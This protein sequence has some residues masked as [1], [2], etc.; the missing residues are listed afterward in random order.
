[1]GDCLSSSGAGSGVGEIE[2]INTRNLMIMSSWARH[3]YIMLA[4]NYRGGPRS[5][6]NDEDGGFDVHDLLALI[7]A[8]RSLSNAD[9][10]IYFSTA[11]HGA[12]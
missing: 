5:E 8:S 2:V 4:S 3:G 12:E 9:R 11:N 1:M 10:E 6:G 7:K